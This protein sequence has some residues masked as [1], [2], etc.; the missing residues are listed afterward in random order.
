MQWDQ[1]PQYPA[2]NSKDEMQTVRLQQWTRE[3]LLNA[4]TDAFLV[5][6]FWNLSRNS[7]NTF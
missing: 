6:V 2:S 1:L 7:Y 3:A 5:A 4:V